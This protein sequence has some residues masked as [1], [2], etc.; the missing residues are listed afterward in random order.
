MKHAVR[1]ITVISLLVFVSGCGNRTTVEYLSTPAIKQ[2]KLPFSEAV[3]VNN[4]LYLS[5]QIGNI[6][7]QMKLVDGGIQA[8]TRQVLEN[9]KA[10]L[11]RYGAEMDDIVKCTVFLVDIAEWPRMNEVYKTFFT[12]NYPA[13][14]AMAGTGL[15]LNARVE[16]ECIAVVK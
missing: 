8:E 2:L 15:A 7:G 16:I 5:G 6:P 9:I 1:V 14:S 13:R 11:Q 3:R 10:T 4:T 12:V